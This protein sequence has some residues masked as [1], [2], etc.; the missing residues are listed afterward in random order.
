MALGGEAGN[1]PPSSQDRLG[2]QDGRHHYRYGGRLHH[3]HVDLCRLDRGEFLGLGGCAVSV[4][5]RGVIGL[6]A[7]AMAPSTT[8]LGQELEA[9]LPFKN[10]DLDEVRQTARRLLNLQAGQPLM[11]GD[12]HAIGKALLILVGDDQ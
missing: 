2:I 11:E 4:T 6:L 10:E 3:R 12:M 5:R 8:F 9:N 7:S 1:E